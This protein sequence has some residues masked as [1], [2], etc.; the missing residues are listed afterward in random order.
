MNGKHGAYREAFLDYVK[1]ARRG[2]LKPGSG[3]SLEAR[4]GAS[5]G[6]LQL[7]FLDYLKS[8]ARRP[9]ERS[10]SGS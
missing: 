9:G 10:A 3:L 5:Y 4:L 2:M 8:G 6:K 1:D 7:E